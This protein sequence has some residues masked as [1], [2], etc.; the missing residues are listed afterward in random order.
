MKVGTGKQIVGIVYLLA[1]LLVSI[2]GV[3]S[4][5]HSTQFGWG[6]VAL[7]VGAGI[8][9][10][11]W[12]ILAWHFGKTDKRKGGWPGSGSTSGPRR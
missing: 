9:L 3:V 12:G 7:A 1:G 10:I 6:G 11:V 2:N 8:W 5:P 4:G